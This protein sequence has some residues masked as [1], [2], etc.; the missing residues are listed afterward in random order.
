M[1]WEALGAIGETIGAVG[2]IVSLMY[3][4]LQI[5]S[6]NTESRSAAITEWTNQWNDWT[7]S[8]ANNPQLSNLWIKGSA[9]YAALEAGERVQYAAHCGRL[10]RIAEG[11]FDQHSQGRLDEKAWRG[12]AGT[13][14]DICLLPGVKVWWPTRRHWYNEDF[15]AF[16][17]PQIASA[18][19][20][21]L[22]DAIDSDWRLK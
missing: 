6:Q 1:N 7:G 18:E 13:I 4:A 12:L 17:E 2:V 3:L 10:F 16:V 8:F 21:R 15:I 9:D 14:E 22:Y 5:R 20:Q 11:L 19:R